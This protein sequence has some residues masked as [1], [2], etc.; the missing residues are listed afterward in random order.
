MRCN[1]LV[2]FASGPEYGSRIRSKDLTEKPTI[3]MNNDTHRVRPEAP[4][5]TPTYEV[6]AAAPRL[7]TIE[8]LHAKQLC[9]GLRVFEV[10]YANKEMAG[11]AIDFLVGDIHFMAAVPSALLRNELLE[12]VIDMLDE[13]TAEADK[14]LVAILQVGTAN[15]SRDQLQKSHKMYADIN[16]VVDSNA[17]VRDWADHSATCTTPERGTSACTTIGTPMTEDP[18]PCGSLNTVKNL[19]KDFSVTDESLAQLIQATDGHGNQPPHGLY[20]F[21]NIVSAGYQKALRAY[22]SNPNLE[23]ENGK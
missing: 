6:A 3:Y 19:L 9:Q 17:E 11:L 15:G 21:N 16:G 12:S 20:L 14:P 18:A 7:G 22:Y 2:R 13:E 8:S 1:R 5:S 4:R 23:W 10:R